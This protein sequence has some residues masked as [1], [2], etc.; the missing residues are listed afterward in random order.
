MA[1]S[2]VLE[3]L[4]E[5]YQTGIMPEISIVTAQKQRG[6]SKVERVAYSDITITEFMLAKFEKKAMTEEEVPFK[7]G[8]FEVLETI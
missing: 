5:A 6:T 7:F 8:N 3:E 2:T 1:D 4:A